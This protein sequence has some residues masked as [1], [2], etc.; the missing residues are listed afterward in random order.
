MELNKKCEICG[1]NCTPIA[2]QSNP[3]ASEFYCSHCH[4]SYRMPKEVA[5]YI[6][7]RGK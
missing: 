7:A 4:E 5:D 2:I 3:P 1:E 6:S